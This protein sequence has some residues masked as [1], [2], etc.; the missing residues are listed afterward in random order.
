MHPYFLCFQLSSVQVAALVSCLA[1]LAWG[2]AG[3]P[4]QGC[5]QM[6]P[7]PPPLEQLA[8]LLGRRRSSRD[9]SSSS[10]ARRSRPASSAWCS[11]GGQQSFGSLRRS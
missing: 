10:S 2:H 5:G 4:T 6:L 7:P 9:S 1:L 11:V 3:G 8:M